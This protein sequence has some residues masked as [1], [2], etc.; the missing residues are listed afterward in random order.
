MSPPPNPVVTHQ[1]RLPQNVSITTYHGGNA[2]LGWN[3]F[4]KI[5]NPA[6]VASNKF[7]LLWSVP[8]DGSVNGSPLIFN[9]VLYAVTEN[10]SVFALNSNNGA[11]L[12]SAKSLIPQLTSGQFNGYWEGQ[13]KHGVLS[14]PVI[15]EKSKTLYFCGPRVHGL[16]QQYVVFALNLETGKVKSGWPVV[17]KAKSLGADFT[18]GQVMQRGA[19]SL[20]KNRLYIPFGGRGDIPPWRGWAL[21][22]DTVHPETGMTG[23]CTSP[24]TDGAGVWSAG[25][26]SATDTGE[27]F[28]VTGNGDY[29]LDQNGDNLG[30]TIVRLSPELTFSKSKTDYYTPA[31]FRFLDEQDEDLGGATALILPDFPNCSTPHL[32][33][34]GGKD[35]C[36]Y[37]LNRDNLGG[38]GTE[39]QRTRLFAAEKATYHE[40]IRATSAYFDSG[41]QGKLIFV[42]GDNP[43]D[44]G[45]KGLTALKIV[46][47]GKYKPA[48]FAPIWNTGRDLARPSSPVV[49]SDGEKNGVVWLVEFNER[50]PGKLDAFDALSGKL[51]MQRTIV[52]AR[53]FVSPTAANG[54]VY[55]GA[56]G[57]SCFGLKNGVAK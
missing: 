13:E 22:L 36:A 42:P 21:S 35:G 4:E 28:A 9:R 44:N 33:F 3:K 54:R 32:L 17:L 15:D 14:T 6:S 10:N 53:R 19:L 47:E 38:V 50:K 7:G 40:G 12:W 56:N 37:L 1:N 25:G 18:P 11:I 46:L 45:D 34:T 27:I 29:D 49:T 20:V 24:V 26:L 8:L 2:R 5:L 57:V 48:R 55:V 43:A 31:N 23:F 39:L 41:K 16:T 30:Q 52:G 51:L